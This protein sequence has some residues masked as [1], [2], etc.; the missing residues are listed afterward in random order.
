MTAVFLVATLLVISPRIALAAGLVLTIYYVVVFMIL[1]RPRRLL[2]QALRE[3]DR[4]AFRDAQQLLGGIKTV[5]IYGVERFFVERYARHSLVQA[6]VN[7]RTPLHYH[8]PKY[9]L[10]PVAFGAIVVAVMIYAA[11]GR[12]LGEIIPI[13]GVIGLAGYRLL[14]AMQLLYSQIAVVGTNR[15]ALDEVYGEFASSQDGPADASMTVLPN[16][17]KEP[18]CW[19][20][21][22]GFEGV[23]FQYESGTKPV[24]HDLVLTIPKHTSL[25]VI[26]K[27]G[28]GKSTF[29][30]L[31]MGL[32]LPTGGRIVVDG[33]PL[34]PEMLD[35]WQAGIG[36]V[37][38]EI[39]L[40]D[41]TVARNIALG[42]PDNEI[43]ADRLREAAAAASI[44]EFIEEELPGGFEATVGERG[45]R[46][47]GG[48]RQRIALARAL[49]RRPQLLILDEATSALDNET[50]GQVVEAINNLQ[51]RVTMIV[52]AHRLSTIERC[53]RVLELNS[54]VGLCR[55]ALAV[56]TSAGET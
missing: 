55:P 54:G 32:H 27:T 28:S 24:L 16:R 8:A 43:D 45:V 39:F 35:S 9:F 56:S 33:K 36:Y 41:D 52:V 5:K 15:H 42:L 46:L 50:E 11:G 13:L 3:A 34:T 14:P 23:S 30:D 44:L 17:A 25:G 10:E 19:S 4:G 7:S 12:E 48:Q 31:L 22:I 47:S 40:I 38:Q 53:G 6:R 51:G 29:V 26:G 18:L 21:A 37:P 49:Y 20:G 1:R 2:S